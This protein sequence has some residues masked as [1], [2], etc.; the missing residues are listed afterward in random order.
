MAIDLQLA[1]CGHV[2]IIVISHEAAGEGGQLSL[3]N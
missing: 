1:V 3:P 2:R